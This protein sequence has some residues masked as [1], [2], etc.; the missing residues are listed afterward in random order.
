[1]LPSMPARGTHRRA[2]SR[3]LSLAPRPIHGIDDRRENGRD[4][5]VLSEA[6]LARPNPACLSSANPVHRLLNLAASN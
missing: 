6:V 2:D 5:L 4:L 1:M 3:E